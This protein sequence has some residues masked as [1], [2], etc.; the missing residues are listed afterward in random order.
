MINTAF[1]NGE[2]QILL[3]QLNKDSEVDGACSRPQQE[4]GDGCIMYKHF[5]F[6]KALCMH[7]HRGRGHKCTSS[8]TVTVSRFRWKYQRGLEVPT[9][10]DAS[11][12]TGSNLSNL[13]LNE[14]VFPQNNLIRRT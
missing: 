10:G 6:K 8:I 12:S 7:K 9:S 11:A 14:G 13:S 5:F 1:Q 2:E 3:S 4:P